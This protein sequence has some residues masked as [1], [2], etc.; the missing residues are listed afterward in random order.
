MNG[1]TNPNLKD[2]ISD[3]KQKAIEEKAALWKRIASDLEKSTRNRR[4]VNL[5]RI[6]RHTKANETIIVPGKV[7]G[8]GVLEHKV[9]IAAFSFSEGAIEKLKSQNCELMTINEMMSKNPKGAKVR[10]IG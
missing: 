10:I 8:S 3:L 4:I 2:L 1:T 5:S 6:N 7:L 9:T